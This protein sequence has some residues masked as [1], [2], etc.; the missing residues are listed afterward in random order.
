[1]KSNTDAST[2]LS[3]TGND[4][5]SE[6]GR[7]RFEEKAEGRKRFTKTSV[8]KIKPASIPARPS[9]I[10][11]EGSDNTSKGS[12]K[13]AE[14]SDK[15]SKGSDKIAEGS[16]KTSKGSDKIAEGSDKTSKGSDKIAE[17]SA[18]ITDGL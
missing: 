6:R 10:F 17:G 5:V 8:K 7:L 2:P 14:G 9:A 4:T 13:I 12:E 1:M 16:D 11:A 15:T 3:M 18:K